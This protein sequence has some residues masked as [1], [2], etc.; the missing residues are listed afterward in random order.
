M[1]VVSKW[2]GVKHKCSQGRGL[3]VRVL[4]RLPLTQASP[5][6]VKLPLLQLLNF[7]LD[8]TTLSFAYSPLLPCYLCVLFVSQSTISSAALVG[9][10]FCN[11]FLWFLFNVHITETHPTVANSQTKHILLCCIS[12]PA[13]IY[14]THFKFGLR[15]LGKNGLTRLFAYTWKLVEH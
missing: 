8:G 7:R 2:N 12:R 9:V 14:G 1:A 15:P 11:V 5:I 4:P 3:G 13:L 6:W 10:G